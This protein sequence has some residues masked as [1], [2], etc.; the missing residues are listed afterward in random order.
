MVVDDDFLGG[1]AVNDDCVQEAA[2]DYDCGNGQP[3]MMMAVRG[4][5]R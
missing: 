4:G 2:V 3:S 1:S 5:H